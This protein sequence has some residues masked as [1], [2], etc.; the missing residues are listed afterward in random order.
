MPVPVP[1]PAP[2]PVPVAGPTVV[3]VFMVS[4]L[5]VDPPSLP[6]L[7]RINARPPNKRMRF[8]IFLVEGLNNIISSDYFNYFA[9]IKHKYK[10]WRKN[11]Q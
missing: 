8:I 6:Q 3:D 7:A 5:V 1:V 4:V 9:T 11:R 10:S 2:T